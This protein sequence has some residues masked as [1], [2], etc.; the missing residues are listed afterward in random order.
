M[1][2]LVAIKDREI[3]EFKTEKDREEFIKDLPKEIEYAT[4]EL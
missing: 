2:Y 1:K 3:F 4:S